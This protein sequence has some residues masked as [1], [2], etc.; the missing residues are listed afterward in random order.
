FDDN[1]SLGARAEGSTTA[2]PIWMHYMTE[3]LK[4]VPQERLERPEGLIDLRV[5]A[6]TGTL[7]SALDPEAIVETFMIDTLPREPRPGETIYAPTGEAGGMM[8]AGEP[9]F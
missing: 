5:S 3:A 7:T 9:L 6:Q 2:V 4:G 8:S 1:Q